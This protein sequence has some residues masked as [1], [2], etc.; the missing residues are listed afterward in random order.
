ML[1]VFSMDVSD[2]LTTI[3]IV[4]IGFFGIACILGVIHSFFLNKTRANEINKRNK[5]IYEFIFDFNKKQVTYFKRYNASKIEKY[6]FKDFYKKII[7]NR[8]SFL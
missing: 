1:T 8:R 5:N 7:K 6:S 2:I 4:V 3:S